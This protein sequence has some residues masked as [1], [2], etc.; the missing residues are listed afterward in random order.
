MAASY[1]YFVTQT[2]TSGN[3]RRERNTYERHKLQA[4]ICTSCAL[5][6]ALTIISAEPAWCKASA[7]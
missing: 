7:R 2:Q 3:N 6:I 1:T 4:H 5:C